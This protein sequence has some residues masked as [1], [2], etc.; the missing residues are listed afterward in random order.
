MK[1]SP[2]SPS[3]NQSADAEFVCVVCNKTS[4]ETPFNCRYRVHE[5]NEEILC[6]FFGNGIGRGQLCDRC[7]R[8]WYKHKREKQAANG[9][10]PIKSPKKEHRKAQE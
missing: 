6:G 3:T 5:R 4:S 9:E 10:I 8:K 1:K 2:T 7:Y